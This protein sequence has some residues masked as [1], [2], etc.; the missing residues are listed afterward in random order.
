MVLTRKQKEAM[1]KELVKVD[2]RFQSMEQQLDARFQKTEQQI[3]RVVYLVARLGAKKEQL[4][5]NPLSIPEE[6]EKKKATYSQD[7]VPKANVTEISRRTE[8]GFLPKGTRMD[9]LKFESGDPIEWVYCV[10]QFFEFNL[11]PLELQ[12]WF[13][14]SYL[15]GEALQWFKWMNNIVKRD[16]WEQFSQALHTRFGPSQFDDYVEILG[17]IKAY[18]FH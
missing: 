8:V 6:D 16:G 17:K 12:I 1:E 10:E 18:R 3:Q 11:T 9:F 2:Q 4:T 5:G 15:R 13:S 14:S 7:R